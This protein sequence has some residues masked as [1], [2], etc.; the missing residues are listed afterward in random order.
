MSKINSISDLVEVLGATSVSNLPQ[1]FAQSV[2][3]VGTLTLICSD[4]SVLHEDEGSDFWDEIQDIVG[5]SFSGI[6]EGTAQTRDSGMILFPVSE[7]Q[8]FKRVDRV[9]SLCVDDG[10]AMHNL[11]WDWLDQHFEISVTDGK[12]R[13]ASNHTEVEVSDEA[14]SQI[15]ALRERVVR[16]YDGVPHIEMRVPVTPVK[17]Q[18]R[19]VGE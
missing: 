5:L 15:A 1:A 17:P 14:A 3:F 8:F 18:L 4:G 9:E 16:H 6:V 12:V 2:G 10:A 19:A 11:S 7:T 13:Y